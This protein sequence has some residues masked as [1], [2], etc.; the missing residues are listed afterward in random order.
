MP[1]IIEEKYKLDAV[2]WELTLKCN[3]YCKHCGSLASYESE[4][5]NELHLK[6]SFRLIQDISDLGAKTITLSGGEPFLSPSWFAVA[7]SITNSNLELRFVSNGTLISGA[8]I[9]QLKKLKRRPR[10]GISLDGGKAETHD[11]LR[12]QNGVFKKVM[13]A[14]SRLEED[15]FPITIITSVHKKNIKE[16]H[17]IFD[18]IKQHN[19]LTWQIQPAMPSGRMRDQEDMML[20]IEDF[21]TI[22][23]FI[24]LKHPT[25]PI[26]IIA[27]DTLGYFSSTEERLRSGLWTGCQAGISAVG[28]R[29]NGDITGCLSL[30]ET[31]AEGNVRDKSLV[32]IWNDQNSFEY[33]RSFTIESLGENCSDCHLGEIC[34]GGCSFLSYSYTNT[35]HNNP[36]C[37]KKYENLESD[38]YILI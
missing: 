2:V 3:L 26:E 16:L 37:I 12:N 22:A 35:F 15:N 33:N 28:I 30:Q 25:S 27:G 34:K 14:I 11:Q 38:K 10:I 6:E 29:S 36:M 17:N 18:L 20:S 32:E 1:I 21:N 13:K 8:I 24:Y 9:D 5:Q 4:R 23:D 19:N 7:S 31:V